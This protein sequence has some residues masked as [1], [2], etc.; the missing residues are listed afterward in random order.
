M[1]TVI[2]F[3]QTIISNYTIKSAFQG[4]IQAIHALF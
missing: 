2:T 3:I 1:N 4:E